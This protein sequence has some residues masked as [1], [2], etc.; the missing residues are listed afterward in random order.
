MN[1]MVRGKRTYYLDVAPGMD[2][3]VAVGSTLYLNERVNEGGDKKSGSSGSS[4]GWVG[5][6][7]GAAGGAA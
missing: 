3:S 4:A 6:V 1:E 5:A 7:A 2:I